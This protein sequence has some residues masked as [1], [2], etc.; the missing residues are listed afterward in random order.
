MSGAQ[1]SQGKKFECD[2]AQLGSCLTG[3]LNKGVPEPL[4]EAS[5]STNKRPWT[6]DKKTYIDT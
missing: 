1:L 3:V 4:P 5:I 6:N 2:M